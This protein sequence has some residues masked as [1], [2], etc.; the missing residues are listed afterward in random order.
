VLRYEVIMRVLTFGIVILLLIITG[1]GESPV[2]VIDPLDAIIAGVSF[3]SDSAIVLMTQPLIISFHLDMVHQSVEDALTF[4]PAFSY[5]A[6]WTTFPPC[7]SSDIGCYPDFYQIYL[8]PD[9]SYCPNT[10]YTCRLDSTAISIINIKL[11][12]PFE[13]EFTTDLTRLIKIEALNDMIDSTSVFPLAI[14][15]GFNSTMELNSM[16]EPFIS[17]PEFDYELYSVSNN[18]TIFEY[19]ITSALRTETSY[20]V[21]AD[22]D[23]YDVYDNIAVD[24]KETSFTTDPVEVLYYYPNTGTNLKHRKPII[25]VRFNTV[26][27]R[28]STEASFSIE[29]E[30]IPLSGHHEWLTDKAMQFFLDN[31]L[32]EGTQVTFSVSTSAE[33][34]YGAHL[35]DPHSFT[36]SL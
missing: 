28:E 17:R 22:N 3:G 12:H 9:T 13:F 19:R 6:H 16:A 14:R 31:E 15:L 23:L 29:S 26:M 36:F 32:P 25:Q 8:Y 4:D 11:P 35:K 18:H 34:T 1:C 10:T 7:N 20:I 21:E 24:S 27:D 33:D 2:K 30:G 5:R